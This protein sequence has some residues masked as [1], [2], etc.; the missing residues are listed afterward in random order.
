MKQA[1][2]LILRQGMDRDPDRIAWAFED[3]IERDKYFETVDKKL[4]PKR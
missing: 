1:I 3:E 4:A 2:F